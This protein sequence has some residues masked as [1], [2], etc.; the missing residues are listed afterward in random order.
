[1]NFIRIKLDYTLICNIHDFFFFDTE[2]KSQLHKS[3]CVFK[4]VFA[5]DPKPHIT[6]QVRFAVQLELIN[7]NVH[8]Q[9]KIHRLDKPG[10]CNK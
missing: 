6:F 9:E 8:F 1:M 10:S 3:F 5:I 2:K 7:L 4:N